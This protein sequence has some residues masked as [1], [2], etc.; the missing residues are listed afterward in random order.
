ML[1]PEL[2]EAGGGRRRR[3]PVEGR[4]TGPDAGA[5]G[6]PVYGAPERGGYRDRR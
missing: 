1:T 2:A 5:D 6:A 3:A 4:R